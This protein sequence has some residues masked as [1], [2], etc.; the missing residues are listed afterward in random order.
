MTLSGGYGIGARILYSRQKVGAD[1]LEADNIAKETGAFTGKLGQKVANEIVTMVDD[2]SLPNFRGTTNF[3]DEGTQMKRNVM[4]RK[5]VLEKYLSRKVIVEMLEDG[6]VVEFAGLLQEYSGKYLLLRDVPYQP[7]VQTG[8]AL[9]D[10]FD[11]IFPR[12]LALVR[13][14]V[15]ASPRK[16]SA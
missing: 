12:S 11:I 3:D 13:H 2:G 14:C 4:I 9:P 16:P 5:G 6:K 1:P 15:G 8:T 10:R 7:K